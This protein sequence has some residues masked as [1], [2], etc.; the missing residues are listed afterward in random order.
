MVNRKRIL[1]TKMSDKERI[2]LLSNEILQIVL[3]EKDNIVEKYP[4]VYKG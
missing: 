1:A 3:H 2:S 4:R